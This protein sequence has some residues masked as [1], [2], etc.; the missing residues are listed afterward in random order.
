M[1]PEFVD[2]SNDL[3]AFD[4]SNDLMTLIGALGNFLKTLS[5][6]VGSCREDLGAA[7]DGV[8]VS[9][10]TLLDKVIVGF[11]DK[12]KTDAQLIAGTPNNYHFEASKSFSLRLG[13][14]QVGALAETFTSADG[15]LHI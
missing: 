13:K 7:S 11:A 2:G 6:C 3:N 8:D 9:I 14:L 10:H 5:Q 12:E 15:T 1:E 4:S